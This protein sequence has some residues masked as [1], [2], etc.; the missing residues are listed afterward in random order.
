LASICI[1]GPRCDNQIKTAAEVYAK[2]IELI[3]ADAV[4]TD[5][6]LAKIIMYAHSAY[7]V[8]VSKTAADIETIKAFLNSSEFKT[9]YAVEEN[10]KNNAYDIATCFNA[11]KDYE[12]ALSTWIA[13][14]NGYRA[15]LIAIG[16]SKDSAKIIECLNL[17][18]D[19]PLK[20]TTAQQLETIV[21]KF[22]KLTNPKYDESLKACMVA[23]NRAFY[24]NIGKSDAWKQAVVNLQL[25]MKAYGIPIN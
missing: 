15:L 14:G 7:Y 2:G 4:I 8:G 13:G 23:L 22:G 12:S 11:V 9:W 21:G 20:I 16:H 24:P 10:K 19:N 3:E 6:V 25:K 17:L 5:K 18:A 1:A